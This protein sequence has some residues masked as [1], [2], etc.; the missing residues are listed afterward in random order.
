MNEFVGIFL[1]VL[2]VIC[3]LML[4]LTGWVGLYLYVREWKEISEVEEETFL[5]FVKRFIIS[6]V[7][8]SLMVSI[9]I[10]TFIYI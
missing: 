5:S 9:T 1:G 4:Y 3:V 2:A 8:L 6:L 10:Y 7:W